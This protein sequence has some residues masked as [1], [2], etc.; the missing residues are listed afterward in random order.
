MI[1]L[2]LLETVVPVVNYYILRQDKKWDQNLK[3][4]QNPHHD[5]HQHLMGLFIGTGSAAISIKHPDYHSLTTII[6]AI[7][8][9]LMLPVSDY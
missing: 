6:I 8:A 1:L 4:H 2:Q 7:I 9:T 3:Q 5:D